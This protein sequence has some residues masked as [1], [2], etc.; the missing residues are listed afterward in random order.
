MNTN[1]PYLRADGDGG[2]QLFEKQKKD[3]RKKFNFQFN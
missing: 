3:E 1:K 2:L